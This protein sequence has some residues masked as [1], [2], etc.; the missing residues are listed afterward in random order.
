[1]GTPLLQLEDFAWSGLDTFVFS[2]LVSKY[3]PIFVSL[4]RKRNI[5]LAVMGVLVAACVAAT[6]GL[7]GYYGAPLHQ[8][9]Q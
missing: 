4:C 1:M 3:Y 5:A 7:I 2:F 9:Q 6:M 8:Y